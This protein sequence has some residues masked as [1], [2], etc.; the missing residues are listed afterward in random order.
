[1]ADVQETRFQENVGLETGKL[2]NVR[3]TIIAHICS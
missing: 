1:M 3:S 2:V